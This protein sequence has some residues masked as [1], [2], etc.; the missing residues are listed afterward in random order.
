VLNLREL[1][2]AAVILGGS[3]CGQRLQRIAQSDAHTLAL[4][5]YADRSS[6]APGRRH[7][8]LSCSPSAARVSAPAR[9]PR[10]PGAPPRFTQYLRAH[11]GNARIAGVRLL[12]GDRQLALRL[13]AREGDFD[14]LLSIFG[15]RSNLYLLDA[16]GRVVTALPGRCLVLPHGESAARR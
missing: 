16:Q 10:A 15:R 5:C 6:G 13:R 1:E 7:L 12:G 11:V 9:A 3:L 8:L 4:T 14:L 2:R